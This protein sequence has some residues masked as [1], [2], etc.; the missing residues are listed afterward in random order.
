MRTDLPG[1]IVSKHA[2]GLLR[3]LDAEE[4]LLDFIRLT[5]PILEPSRELILGWPLEAICE[6]LEAVSRGEIRR[7][8]VNVPPGFMKSLSAVFWTAWEWGPQNRPS[9]R[10]VCASYSEALTV[11]DNLRCRRLVQSDLYRDL[12]G[13]R[14]E[15]SSDQF[16]KVRFDNSETGFRLATSVGGIGTGERGDRF[17]VDDAHSVQ[18]VESEATRESTLRWF[19]EVVPTRLNDPE[20]SAII[21]I[22]QRTHERDVAG[23]ILEKELGYDSLVIP[24]EYEVG[25][26]YPS[27]TAIGWQD[28]RTED[29]ELAWPERFSRRHLEE[30]LKPVLRS[31]GGTYAEA[32]Q[33]QQRP[34]PRGGGMFQRK[35]FAIIDEPLERARRVRGW[36]LAASQQ[37]AYTVGCLM[38]L[39]LDGRLAIEDIVRLRGNPGE[40]EAVIRKTVEADGQ[41]IEQSFPQDPGQAGKVQK[42]S[43]ARL[44][45]GFRIHFSPESGSKVTRAEGLS[46][47]AASG[48]VSLVR[49]PWVDD[50]LSEACSFPHGAFADQVDAA[51]RAYGRLI[52]TRRLVVGGAPQSVSA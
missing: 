19:T 43:I 51:S 11:R 26:P 33:L 52:T 41:G 18:T 22:G 37:G 21:V 1:P 13:E 32:G 40:T 9:S 30:D 4:S 47:Q 25:H 35:D 38:A 31:W 5:W 17:I 50:F 42:A 34:A 15:I 23:L 46:G 39:D 7:L 8:L 49:A 24:M 48:N 20:R 44:C 6:H 16:A 10:Y 36:D 28:P 12:W 14:F 27:H 2:L 3:K 29:G 45:H